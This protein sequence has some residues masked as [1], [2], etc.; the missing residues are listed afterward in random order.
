LNEQRFYD[1]LFPR[2]LVGGESNLAQQPSFRE[3]RYNEK[4]QKILE[5]AAK[6]FAKKGYENVSLEEIAAKL[7]LSKASI[8]YYFKSKDEMSFMIQMQ[9]IEQANSALEQVL[10]SKA[11]S[12]EKLREAIKGHVRI[13]TKDYFTGTF[14]QRELILPRE[15][16][17][18]VIAARD[19]FEKNFQKIILEG[20]EK[21]VFQG[22]YWKLASLAILGTLNAIPRWYSPKGEL[23]AEEIGE[24]LAGFVIKGLS[25]ND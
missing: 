18:R 6:L 14:R 5:H 2:V 3:I 10:D 11:E 19:R 17:A 9:A 1:N 25:A 21:G 23:S 22:K 15:L 20:V 16:M 4:R 24:A 8:Y 7:K 12:K 13:V